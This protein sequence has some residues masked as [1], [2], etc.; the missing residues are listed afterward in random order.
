[1]KQN[2]SHDHELSP[3]HMEMVRDASSLH[4]MHLCHIWIESV[5][6]ARSHRADT[7]K[8]LSDLDL[9]PYDLEM[10]LNTSSPHGLY[11]C[12][13]QSDSVKEAWS[14]RAHMAKFSN[15]PRDLDLWLFQLEI[16]CNTSSPHRL[17]LCH[18]TYEVN[19]SNRH[20]IME[21]TLQKP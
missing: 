7:A 8:T 4:C 16:V 12:Y 17:Y 14:H 10:L 15:D 3:F 9:W 5:K 11:L 21:R 20:G 6:K 1:M 2:Y 13:I 19:R 18:I